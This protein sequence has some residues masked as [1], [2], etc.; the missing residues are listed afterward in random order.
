MNLHFPNL[1]IEVVLHVYS[2]HHPALQAVPQARLPVAAPQAVHHHQVALLPAHHLVHQVQVRVPAHHLVPQVQV[3]V[4]AHH[5]V[6]QVHRH[7]AVLQVEHLY[8]Y[9]SSMHQ[10]YSAKVVKQA[11]GLQH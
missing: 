10:T 4:P 7:Q 1:F 6:P 8:V 5:L 9:L 2:E 3:R 11:S